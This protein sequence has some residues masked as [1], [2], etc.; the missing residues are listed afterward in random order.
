M[1]TFDVD[2][3]VDVVFLSHCFL[4]LFVKYDSDKE[5]VGDDTKQTEYNW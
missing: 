3:D 5:D 2:V 1:R 4:I